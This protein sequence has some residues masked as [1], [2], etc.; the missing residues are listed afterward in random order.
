[1]DSVIS[2]A[3]CQNPLYVWRAAEDNLTA[4]CFWWQNWP[5]GDNALE[6]QEKEAKMTF[7]F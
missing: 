6:K 4:K 7:S 2:L 5:A 3:R 1:M